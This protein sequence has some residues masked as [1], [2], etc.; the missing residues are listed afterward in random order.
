L[1]EINDPNVRA[2][3]MEIEKQVDAASREQAEELVKALVESEIDGSC[4]GSCDPADIRCRRCWLETPCTK[5]EAK[6]QV[7]SKEDEDG[8]SEVSKVSEQED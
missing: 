6:F 2:R 5:L 1:T 7:W 3:A 4:F 8:D